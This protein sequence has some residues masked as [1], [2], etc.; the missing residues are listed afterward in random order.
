MQREGVGTDRT[1]LRAPR[2]ASG[3]QANRGAGCSTRACA[4]IGRQAGRM[5]ANSSADPPVSKA[6]DRAPTVDCSDRLLERRSLLFGQLR[7]PS[8]RASL[9]VG[10]AVH[11]EPL[12]VSTKAFTSGSGVY[13]AL[14]S[15]YRTVRGDGATREDEDRRLHFYCHAAI[16]NGV[17]LVLPEVAQEL[18][19]ARDDLDQD[20]QR[21]HWRLS[22]ITTHGGNECS[23]G[24]TAHPTRGSPCRSTCAR[25]R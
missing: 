23:T 13:R 5:R 25:L 9:A 12:D 19:V 4:S 8:D 10:L 2:G 20:G 16:S 22:P 21:P 3:T 11:Q 18:L 14:I 24:R 17:V 1:A 7:R 6:S 15:L